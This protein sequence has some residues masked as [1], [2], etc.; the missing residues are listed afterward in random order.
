MIHVVWLPCCL[1]HLQKPS[2]IHLFK[3]FAWI[4]IYEFQI[5]ELNF[6][7]LFSPLVFLI[8]SSFLMAITL[9]WAVLFGQNS[10]SYTCHFF[11]FLHASLSPFIFHS[12]SPPAF[13]SHFHQ[14]L[15]ELLHSFLPSYLSV[16]C[17][18]EFFGTIFAAYLSCLA[19]KSKEFLMQ[20]LFCGYSIPPCSC[21]CF[22]PFL[23]SLTTRI[24][25]CCLL[26]FL[27]CAFP[28][29]IS[30]P[31]FVRVPQEFCF[32]LKTFKGLVIT[33]IK[34]KT[35]TVLEINYYFGI[36]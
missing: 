3:P 26:L 24:A 9:S 7:S 10:H 22:C 17:I 18:V 23:F 36:N 1:S 19:V 16:H 35:W 2:F 15:L 32:P 34:L 6:P 25:T 33:W 8:H 11:C 4:S 30:N 12:A 20:T 29:P 21:T 31:H 14:L 13:T 28:F 5:R 27:L